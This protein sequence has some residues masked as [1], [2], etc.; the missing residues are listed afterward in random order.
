MIIEGKKMEVNRRF[1]SS[2]EVMK[3]IGISYPTLLRWK[4][5]GLLPYKKISGQLLFPKEHFNNLEAESLKEF[6]Q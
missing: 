4:N 1:L 3:T 5:K 6:I 2:K